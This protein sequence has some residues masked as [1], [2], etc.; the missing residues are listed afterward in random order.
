MPRF[1]KRKRT[2]HGTTLP[3]EMKKVVKAVANGMKV[4]EA[5]RQ[6][7]ILRSTLQHN[8]EKAKSGAELRPNYQ[9]R[10]IFSPAEESIWQNISILVQK[11]FMA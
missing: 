1:Y 10:Q 4:R 11:C 3:E 2:A 6:D 9:N 8:I 7:R 5:A